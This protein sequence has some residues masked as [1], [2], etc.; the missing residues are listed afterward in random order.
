MVIRLLLRFRNIIYELVSESKDLKSSLSIAGYFG[1][2]HKASSF[3][4]PNPV[5]STL[6][7]L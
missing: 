3:M 2:R 1:R 4:F 5:S 7:T 6:T